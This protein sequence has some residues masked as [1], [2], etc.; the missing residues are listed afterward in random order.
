MLFAPAA[1][2]ETRARI[3]EK[4]DSAARQKAR[5]VGAEAGEMA[6]EKLKNA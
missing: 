5:E 6:Y 3:A 4:V 2:A 1:G